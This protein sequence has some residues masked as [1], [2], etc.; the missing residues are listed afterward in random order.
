MSSSMPRVTVCQAIAGVCLLGAAL[1]A[2]SAPT[3][4]AKATAGESPIAVEGCLT[5]QGPQG[6]STAAEQF[7]LVLA[8]PDRT[9]GAPTT[10]GSAPAPPAPKMYALRSGDT[11]PIAFASFVNQRVKVEGTTT[12]A[13]TSAPLAGRSPEAT[14]YPAPVASGSAPSEPTG[15]PFDRANL[16]TIVVRTLN[17]VAKTCT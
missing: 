3:Q 11:T 10:G 7:V 17:A 4:P 15:T 5:K 16:P 13:A 1:S 8:A 9:T 6:T 14:P 12:A 2:Q